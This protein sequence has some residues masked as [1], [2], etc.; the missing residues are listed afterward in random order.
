MKTSASLD[1]SVPTPFLGKKP[2]IGNASSLDSIFLSP[3]TETVDER[4]DNTND[5][6]AN[7]AS[8]CV[9]GIGPSVSDDQV[10]KVLAYFKKCALDNGGYVYEFDIENDQCPQLNAINN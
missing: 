8:Y 9:P 2:I 1:A 4:T 5:A 3:A 10:Q 7:I 6:S